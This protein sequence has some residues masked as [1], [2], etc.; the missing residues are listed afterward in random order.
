MINKHPEHPQNPEETFE[1]Y[2]KH[3][4]VHGTGPRSGSR[5]TIDKKMVTRRIFLLQT[6][7]GYDLRKYRESLGM[8]Q[9]E[10]AA[11]LGVWREALNRW[12]NGKSRIP[13]SVACLVI[14]CQLC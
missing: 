12:E 13:V 14:T 2:L 7:K 11:Y 3:V 5:P 10:F 4:K 9:G 8:N 1:Q 6:I